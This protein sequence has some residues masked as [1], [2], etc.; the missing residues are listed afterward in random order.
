MRLRERYQKLARI[1]S[2][3]FKDILKQEPLVLRDRIRL[4]FIDESFMDIH[5]PVDHDYSFH[6]QRKRE[7]YRINTAPNHPEIE[8]F[9][10]HIHAGEEE[11]ITSDTITSPNN[12]PEENLRQVLKWVKEKLKNKREE[13]K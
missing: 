12:P 13:R 11:N 1:T 4:L 6:W 7:L 5:Y 9:P 2:S 3:E 10:R 8:T